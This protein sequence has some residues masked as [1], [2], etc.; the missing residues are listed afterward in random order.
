[1]AKPVSGEWV[2]D[3]FKGIAQH[4]IDLIV[5]LLEVEEARD[6]GLAAEAKLCAQHG[7]QFH[8]FPIKDR[9]LPVSMKEFL[10]FTKML[11]EKVTGGAHIVIH[12]RAGIGRTGIVAAGVMMHSGV[13][14]EDGVKQISS[15]RRVDVPDTQE[16]LDWVKR[17]YNQLT[18]VHKEDVRVDKAMADVRFDCQ[19]IRMRDAGDRAKTRHA[20]RRVENMSE[21]FFRLACCV[22]YGGLL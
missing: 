14:P 2:D 4:G 20:K 19:S 18:M 11:F 13:N 21:C 1:M 3:E 17:C 12:C 5:S 8:Q 16:Q 6:L 15:A 10:C 9:G 22:P 7:M